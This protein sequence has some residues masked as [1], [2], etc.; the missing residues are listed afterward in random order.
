MGAITSQ[1]GTPNNKPHIE[2]FFGTLT[3]GILQKLPGT[4]FSNPT[5]RG[6]YDSSG[7]ALL[8]LDH[9]KK[10]VDEWINTVYHLT[11]HNSTGRAP[12]LLWQDAI[13]HIK[14][15][16]MTNVD[17][18]IICRRP[19]E[20]TINNGQVI[21]DG[22]SYFSHALTTLQVDGVKKVIVLVNDLNLSKVFITHP[23]KKDLVIQADSTNPEYT[24]NLSHLT[25]LE[26]QKRKK[27]MTESDKRQL[28]KFIDLYNLYGLMQDIQADLVRR[29]PKL[30]Q[31]KIELP[32][33]LNGRF[34]KKDVVQEESIAYLDQRTD[35]QKQTV[36]FG[37]MEMK[38]HGKH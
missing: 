11:I 9:V 5:E 28:G 16:S 14:P 21:V 37:S 31:L 8:T 15:T 35:Q 2:R 13:Q 12:A 22:L 29:K 3:Q 27:Q 19:I 24:H 36:R 23:D 4:T 18:D 38:R 32:Q 34:I 1:V 30:K 33:H 26:V 17:A 20:R 7:R 6:S 10:Y 25:H